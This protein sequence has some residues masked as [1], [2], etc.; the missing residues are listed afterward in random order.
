MSP[1]HLVTV[2]FSHTHISSATCKR[3]EKHISDLP[4][5]PGFVCDYEAAPYFYEK[6]LTFYS[7][8]YG[9]PKKRKWVKFF[10]I[11]IL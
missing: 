11:Q 8:K 2:P 10:N 5:L 6:I 9:T 7:G 4:Y 1:G 3:C